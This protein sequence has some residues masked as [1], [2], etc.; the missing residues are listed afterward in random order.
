[1]W[2]PVSSYAENASY[3]QRLHVCI[4][5]HFPF[6]TLCFCW[7]S[8]PIKDCL[9]KEGYCH[10]LFGTLL[11]TA[12]YWS[13]AILTVTK[14]KL[15]VSCS[16]VHVHA[17]CIACTINKFPPPPPCGGNLTLVASL[18]F[19]LHMYHDTLVTAEDFRMAFDV[20]MIVNTKGYARIRFYFYF[21]IC[22][23][24]FSFIGQEGKKITRKRFN[25]SR[26]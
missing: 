17:L 18:M 1:V 20:N 8:S 7:P 13:D 6:H 12:L 14:V 22:V 11:Y 26:T 5:E 25:I 4:L 3:Q 9:Q 10:R 2:W 21:F 19:I 24:F 23:Y 15:L 16:L